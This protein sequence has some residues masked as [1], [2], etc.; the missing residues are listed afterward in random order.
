M[1]IVIIFQEEN[2]YLKEFLHRGLM[3]GGFG[4]II[5]AIIIL[6]VSKT[7]GLSFSGNEIFFAVISTYLLAF[8]QAGVSVFNQ[9][10]EW[11]ILKSTFIHLSSLYLAYLSCY[12][13]NSWIPFEWGVVLVFTMSFVVLYFIVWLIVF[14]T[15]KKTTQHLN[16]KIN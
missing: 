4:P 11:S 10:D 12:L 9:I 7:E 16:N 3:F 15:V 6:C 13:L 2:K 1:D 5:M 8:I 14:I